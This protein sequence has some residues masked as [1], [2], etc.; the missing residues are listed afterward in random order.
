MQKNLYEFHMRS[1]KKCYEEGL[2]QS[3]FFIEREL[4]FLDQVFI[5]F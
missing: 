4:K 5:I 3:A 1:I 2:N